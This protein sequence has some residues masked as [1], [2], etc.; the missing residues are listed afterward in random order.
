V[1]FPAYI[2][3]FGLRLHPHPVFELSAYALSFTVYALTK[4]RFPRANAG[5]TAGLWIAAGAMTGALIGAVVLNWLEWLGAPKDLLQTAADDHTHV[6]P[7]GKTVA[8]GLLGGWIGVE[9]VKKLRGI[10]HSTGDAY[11]LPLAL[12]M[13]LGR[14]GCF[15]TGLADHTY[16][17]ASDLPWAVD[18]GDGIP[19]HPCQ[20][21]DIAFLL[22]AAGMLLS[23]YARA[24]KRA[25]GPPNGLLFRCFFAAYFLWRFAV[26]FIKPRHTQLGPLSAIQIA[27]LLGAIAAV[28]SAIRLI[29]TCDIPPGPA[30]NPPAMPGSGNTHHA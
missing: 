25:P 30:S 21:Y 20:L 3:L 16:G 12:G 29:R 7:V 13:A 8:G 23:W 14:V 5:E 15:L 4:R 2:E 19:R 6:L 10:R 24:R 17:V 9:L 11:V 1:Q 18:F 28:I 22:L 26:E 27:S